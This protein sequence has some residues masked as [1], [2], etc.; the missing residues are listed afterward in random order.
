MRMCFRGEIHMNKNTQDMVQRQI[1]IAKE[2]LAELPQAKRDSNA[3]ERLRN[4]LALAL[5]SITALVE[6][7]AT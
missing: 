3:C 1:V 7:E 4:Q 5:D 6:R 2:A